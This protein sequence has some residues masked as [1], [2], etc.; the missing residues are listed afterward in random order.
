MIINER[1]KVLNQECQCETIL[2]TMEYETWY[3]HLIYIWH[4][5]HALIDLKFHVKACFP[6]FYACVHVEKCVS[7]VTQQRHTWL[8]SILVC[9]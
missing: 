6:R 4:P 5:I 2:Q 8:A 3:V 9:S 1:H 7:F